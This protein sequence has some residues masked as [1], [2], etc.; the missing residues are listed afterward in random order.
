M[1]TA[2][3]RPHFSYEEII[4]GQTIT[5][6]QYQQMLVSSP[7]IIEGVLILIGALVVI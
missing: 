5:I 4:A 2:E 1:A 6:P 3:L 7:I